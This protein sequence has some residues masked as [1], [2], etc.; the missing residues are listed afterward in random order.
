MADYISGIKPLKFHF[1]IEFE[2]MQAQ[3]R[4][5]I[6]E[7]QL[8]RDRLTGISSSWKEDCELLKWCDT[9]PKTKRKTTA[10]A[11]YTI[12]FQIRCWGDRAYTSIAAR[13]GYPDKMPWLVAARGVEAYQEKTGF[14]KFREMFGGDK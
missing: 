3:K 8:E 1:W 5:D 12:I 11:G 2:T 6:D 9:C 4:M 13:G 10:P 7:M 14:A